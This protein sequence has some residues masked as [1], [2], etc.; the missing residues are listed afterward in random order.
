MLDPSLDTDA[1]VPR[2]VVQNIPSGVAGLVIAALFAAAMSSLDSS[3]H[4]V[5]TI[6]V[7]DVVARFRPSTSD[8]AR[9]RWARLLTLLLGL[10]GTG[11]ALWMAAV[12]IQSLWDQFL[13]IAGLFVGGL[14]GLFILG[15]FTR[16]TSAVGAWIGALGSMVVLLWVVNY[17]RVHFFLYSAIG[18][19]ACCAIGYLASVIFVQA[20]S[21]SLDGL[22]HVSRRSRNP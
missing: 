3:I 18:C 22:T 15:I 11:T 14:S 13:T 21:K 9:L 7:T 4:S 10:F 8:Q 2:F 17:T 12:P 5:A 20:D 19:T 16:R 6:W 1:I